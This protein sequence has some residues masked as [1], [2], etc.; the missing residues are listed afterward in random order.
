MDDFITPIN[1]IHFLAKKMFSNC[2]EII[3]GAIAYIEK[4]GGGP[5]DL[6]THDHSHLFIV[7]NGQA[8]I[9]MGDTDKILNSNEAFLLDGKIPH[10]VWNNADETTV[11]L[12]VSVKP[13]ETRGNNIECKSLDEV[14][15]NIDRIDKD[16]IRLIAERSTFVN[17]AAKF[18]KTDSDVEALKRVEQV[19]NK[20][21]GLAQSQNLNPDI[22]ETIYRTMI[23]AFI[24]QE[25]SKL[26]D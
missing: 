23:A 16:L 25:K 10:S 24:Q 1:H 18:K 5:L 13:N 4:R 7:I 19:I 11:M 3:N 15:E 2:G 20:V 8:R 9:R 21:R 22:A 6:H 26:K 17:Q 12:G 14:R